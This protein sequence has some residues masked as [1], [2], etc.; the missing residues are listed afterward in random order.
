M[1][2]FSIEVTEADFEEKVI[3]AS[4]NVL[5]VIDLWAE[6]CGPCRVL[7]PVLERLASAYQGK[8][9][10]A[11]IDAD[12]NMRIAGRYA[13]RGFPT[14]IAFSDGQEVGRFSS[15]QSESTV[16]QFLDRLLPAVATATFQPFEREIKQ[17]SQPAAT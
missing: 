9:I 13:V 12:E 5:V 3:E 15:A 14:V 6:W 4:K 10:L 7:G 8:F 2:A 17:R 16:R 1:S 11:M